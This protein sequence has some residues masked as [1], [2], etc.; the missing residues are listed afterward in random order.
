MTWSD[1][2]LICFAIG[3]LFS[4]LSFILGGVDFHGAWPHVHGLHFGHG[5]HLPT[6][7]GGA[8]HGANGHGETH[9]VSPFNIFTIAIFLAWFGGTGYI[10]TRYST[11][12]LALGLLVSTVVGLIGAGIVFLFLTRVLMTPEDEMNPADYEMVGIVGRI[13]SP[14]RESGT[15]EIMYTQV[16]TR[17][18]CPARSEDNVTIDRDAEVVVTRYEKGIA[19]VRRWEEVAGE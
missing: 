14:I 12:V 16:G 6:A 19:Y 15:G 9:S 3:F 4:L 8:G 10:L 17:R 1:F 18:A 5:G 7:N 2:Y 11:V 13:S